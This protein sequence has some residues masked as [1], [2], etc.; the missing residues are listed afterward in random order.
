MTVERPQEST[1]RRER[2]GIGKGPQDGNRT[3]SPCMSAV[4]LYVD[5]LT[6]RLLAIVIILIVNL[7]A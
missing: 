2:D 6:T 3:W 4:A 5:T 1:M 7:I